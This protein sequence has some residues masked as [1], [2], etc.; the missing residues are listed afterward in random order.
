[1]PSPPQTGERAGVRGED[2]KGNSYTIKLAWKQADSKHYFRILDIY[3]MKQQ[4]IQRI[5]PG[6][7]AFTPFTYSSIPRILE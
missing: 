7:T 6:N 4:K 3:T 2:K 5:P 1:M